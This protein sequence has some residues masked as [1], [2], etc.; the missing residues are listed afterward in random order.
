MDEDGYVANFC[1]TEQVVRLE[2]YVISDLQIRGSVPLFFEQVGLTTR[3]KLNRGYELTH[4]I[5]KKH[6]ERLI[7]HYRRVFFAN[8]LSVG[9]NG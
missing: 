8:L 7:R 2:E 3:T 9:K 4:Q 5:Y 1:E 6:M